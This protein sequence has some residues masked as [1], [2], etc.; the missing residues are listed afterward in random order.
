[1]RRIVTVVVG[2]TVLALAASYAASARWEWVIAITLLGFLWLIEPW[3]RLA[4]VSSLGLIFFTVAAVTGLFLGFPASWSLTIQATVLV[5]WDLDQLKHQLEDVSDVRD[6]PGILKSHARRLGTVISSGLVLGLVALSVRFTFE[7]IPTLALGL[8][9]VI[10]L[11][12][13]LRYVRRESENE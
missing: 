6:E 1:M 9:I 11:S 5:A 13:A 4:W 2:F 12:G 3:H 7:F 8:L 10:S